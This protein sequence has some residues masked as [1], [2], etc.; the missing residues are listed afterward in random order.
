[1]PDEAIHVTDAGTV[2]QQAPPPQAPS[3]RRSSG[4]RS[5]TF[6]L[7]Q[8][9]SGSSFVLEVDTHISNTLIMKMVVGGC[10]ILQVVSFVATGATLG[11]GVA[12][13]SIVYS[14]CRAG[15]ML[16]TFLMSYDEK[17]HPGWLEPGTSTFVLA[18]LCAF[19]ILAAGLAGW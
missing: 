13:Y 4:R 7:A 6:G 8:L 9:T 3:G 2:A 12:G 10:A 1:M 5:S 16:S 17:Y 11:G 19:A 15:A 18:W 14:A